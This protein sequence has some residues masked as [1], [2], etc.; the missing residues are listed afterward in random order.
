M[1]HPAQRRYPAEIRQRAVRMVQELRR[2]DPAD[3]GVIARVAR[4]LDVGAESLRTWVLWRILHITQ[5]GE[6]GILGYPSD[7]TRPGQDRRQGRPAAA[8]SRLGGCPRPMGV[9]AGRI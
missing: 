9:N 2:E 3:H 5:Y 1:R 4:Q 6:P 8:R 7:R